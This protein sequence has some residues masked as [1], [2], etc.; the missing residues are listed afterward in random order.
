MNNLYMS[1]HP[2][3]TEKE[4]ISNRRAVREPLYQKLIILC[5]SKYF[6]K[7][8]NICLIS[9][10]HLFFLSCHSIDTLAA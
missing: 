7:F 6:V 9:Q 8:E 4:N 3:K 2:I 1:K 10:F 5:F